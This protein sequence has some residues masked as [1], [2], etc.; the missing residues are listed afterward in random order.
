MTEHVEDPEGRPIQVGTRLRIWLDN[1]T[2]LDGEVT[3]I[4]DA[5]AEW[6]GEELGWRAVHPRVLVKLDEPGAVEPQASRPMHESLATT[7]AMYIHGGAYVDAKYIL[8]DAQVL[9]S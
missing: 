8:E 5:E 1:N 4:S 3:H 9:D 2:T 6:E 7:V